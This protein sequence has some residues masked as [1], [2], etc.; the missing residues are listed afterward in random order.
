MG[1]IVLN[2]QG[3]IAANRS[4]TGFE[5]VGCAHRCSNRLNGVFA[6]NRH[7]HNGTTGQIGHD[8]LKKWSASMLGVV[9]FHGRSFGDEQ[10]ESNHF[11]VSLFDPFEDLADQVSLDRARFKKNKSRFSCHCLKRLPEALGWPNLRTIGPMTGIL[12]PI[13]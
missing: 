7:G 2:R 13:R 6:L 4:G 11:E 9:L 12:H 5:R 1:Q 10:I 8:A 3:K